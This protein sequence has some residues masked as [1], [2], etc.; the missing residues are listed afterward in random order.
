MTQKQ[1]HF[2]RGSFAL[3]LFVFLGY[4]VKF[5]PEILT[6]FDS[7]IQTAVRGDLSPAMTSFFSTITI[8]GNTGVQI[9]IALVLVLGLYL[10]KWYA[11]AAYTGL[12]AILAGFFILVLKNIYQRPRPSITHLVE[13]HG[14]S[15]PS[16]HSMGSFLI[17]GSLIVIIAGRIQDKKLRLF[18]QALV[19]LL[20]FLIG[21]SRIYLGVHYPSDV[22]AGFS[23][24]YAVV[25]FIYPFYAE[26]RFEWRFQSKQK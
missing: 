12:S 23:M 22:L 5:Y 9:G 13:A 25:S 3:L 7:S 19:A 15:F 26:K 4:L 20:V 8:L 16:G 21:L 24:G 18:L 10:K 2:L 1:T 6:G 14:Y 11:E 17:I